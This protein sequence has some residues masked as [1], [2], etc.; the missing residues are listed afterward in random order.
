MTTLEDDIDGL[1]TTIAEDRESLVE[2]EASLKDDQLYLKDL[3]ERCEARAKDWDQRTQMRANE[4]EAIKQA[5]AI[6]KD[7]KDG[8]SVADMDS[9]VNQRALLQKK[10]GNTQAAARPHSKKAIRMMEDTPMGRKLIQDLEGKRGSGAI[11]LR[12]RQ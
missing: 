11:T 6:L 7:G 1:K 2:E 12:H 3:T 10:S 8:A 5:L 9:E 4:L